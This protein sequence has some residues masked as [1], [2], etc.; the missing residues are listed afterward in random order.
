MIDS[1]LTIWN[2]NIIVNVY[3]ITLRVL[4]TMLNKVV[5]VR[6]NAHNTSNVLYNSNYWPLT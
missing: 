3:G 2:I 6:K 5:F 4:H 1:L